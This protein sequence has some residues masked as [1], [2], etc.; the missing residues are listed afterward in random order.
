MAAILIVEDDP[1]IAN[2]IA[3]YLQHA[4]HAVDQL[5]SGADVVR[6]VKTTPPDLLVL[7]IMLP[8]VDGLRICQT[9]RTDPKTARVPII[10][11]TARGEESDR[12]TGL[13]LGADDY[14]TKPFS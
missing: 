5:R 11:V 4:G 3:R 6:R 8:G 13:E 2:L 10:I 14:V 9:L 12:I 7:D 1:D